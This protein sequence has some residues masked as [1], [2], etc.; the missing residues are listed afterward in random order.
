MSRRIVVFASVG[1]LVVAGVTAI[2]VTQSPTKA[3]TPSHPVVAPNA[4]AARLPDG[5]HLS[6]QGEQ[7]DLGNFPTGGALTADGQFLWTVSAG[8]GSDDVRIV[9]VAQ[10]KVCQTLDLPGASGGVALDSEHRLAYVSGLPNSRWQPSK[11]G[12]PGA[13]D[14]DVQ[15]FSWT[16]TCGQ[17]RLVR[18]IPL[19]PPPNGPTIQTFPPI[20]TR[21]N[22]VGANVKGSWPQKLAVSPDGSRLL[23]PLNLADNAALIDLNQS[24]KVTY[25]PTGSYPFGAAVL[26]GG[27]TG[28]VSNEAAGTLSVV[29]MQ[30]G[31]KIKDITVGA[32]LSHPQGIVIDAAGERAYVALSAS[33]EVVVVDLKELA[34]ERTISV[35]RSIGLGTM[36]VALALGP[37]G[38]R[39]Y[40]ANSGTDEI[41]VIRLPGKATKPALEWTVVGRIPVADQ[42]EALA[43]VAAQGGRPAQLMWVAAKGLDV[44]PNTNG[45]VPTLES[46]PIFWAF[47]TNA[48]TFDIFNGVGYMADV[49]RGRAGLMALPSDAQIAKWTP[50][51]DSQLLPVGGEPAPADTPLR[52]G[53]PIKH[54]FFVV[55][56]NRSYDQVLGDDSRGNGD[57]K[58][59]VFGK[60][61][62]PN[63]HALVD[64]FPLIDNVLANS[65]ASI[66]GHSWTAGASVSDYLSRNWVQQYGGRGRPNDFGVY[67]VS[68]PGNG[69]LFDQAE[70]QQ[71]SYFN[72]GEALADAWP[73]VPDRDR[74][75]AQLA[76][77][78]RVF[79]NT[80]NGP[81]T[82]GCYPSDGTIGMSV[83]N[84]EIFDSALPKG[85]PAGSYSHID[86]FRKRF[87]QQL[88]AGKVPA[89]NYISMTSD[90]TRGTQTGFPTPTAMV[91]DS[92]QAIGQLVET[93]SHS[94]IW[95]SSAIF[96]IEDDSQDGADHVNA[97]RVPAMVISPYARKGAVIHT[98]YDLV[99]IELILGMHALSLNDA[100]ATPMYDAFSPTPDNALPV[101]AIPAQQDLLARNPASAI[102]ASL[103][104]RL[105]L[106]VPDQVPQR[107]LDRI[108]WQ[109]VY[110]AGSAPPPPV[111]YVMGIPAAL[112]R[113]RS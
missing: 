14:S 9:D 17:A 5:R 27:R 97:H 34:V 55:R 33:D 111:T 46:D 18:V 65:E 8:F 68:W 85:A 13:K 4:F 90:H 19:P 98:P 48:P 50:T 89:L 28:L 93:V 71:I 43:A 73:T 112:A 59:T 36:P 12:L 6:P 100:L 88:A 52:A 76:E 110:G 64:R 101:T 74:S 86:C 32:P 1:V 29:D 60:E 91:A 92:D 72:Y 53:G 62:T 105:P 35:G 51:A 57:S 11:N 80:D 49:I 69:F 40:V 10:R 37:G 87:A 56:E 84:K 108:L 44:G 42:P 45:P 47:N 22:Q 81:P 106:G 30:R 25:V 58:L 24:D 3:R 104:S 94:S 75:P 41:V 79:A 83:N 113:L 95:S 15:V 70:R 102:W 103:S 16:A 61:V 7:V 63:M 26:P 107:V 99:S 23:V 39:L 78:K 66:E 20:P 31:V 82:S 2:L 21:S 77:S 96:V 54:V 67:A 38:D 109:S